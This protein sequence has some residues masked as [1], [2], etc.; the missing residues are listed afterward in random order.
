LERKPI[1][2]SSSISTPPPGVLKQLSNPSANDNSLEKA[3]MEDRPYES[4]PPS[5]GH[6][7]LSSLM[8][9][10]LMIAAHTGV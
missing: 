2:L 9:F 6:G 7:W 3:E 1:P 4:L 8:L 10:V 5:H